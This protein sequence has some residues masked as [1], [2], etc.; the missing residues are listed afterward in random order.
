MSGKDIN[1]SQSLTFK[2]EKLLI[3]AVTIGLFLLICFQF[4]MLNDSA[5][6]FL[7]YT[8][9]LEGGPLGE[10]EML[11]KEGSVYVLLENEQLMPRAQLLINGEPVA[12]F[13]NREIE[14]VVKNNDLLEL[15]AARA[16]DEYVNVS[17]VG[18]S[19]N[20]LQPSVGLRIKAKNK[21]EVISRVR[22]K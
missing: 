2:V 16:V 5:R 17:V 6:V 7:N 19:D 14:V 3:K 10:T 18:I 8:S 12:A 21:I 1:K 11:T 20:V 15:D 13:N 4:I 22:L 9:A